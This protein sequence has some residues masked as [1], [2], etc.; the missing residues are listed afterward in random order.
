MPSTIEL[1]ILAQE[2]RLTQA[3]RTLDVE[4]LDRLYA[5][6]ILM[7]SVLGESCDKTFL[8]D[9]AK[10]GVA[11]RAAAGSAGKDFV[12][13]YDKEELKM[14]VYG[15]AAVTTYRFIVTFKGDGIDVRRKYRTTNV[16]VKRAERWQVVAAHTAFVLDPKQIAALA[17]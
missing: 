2:D 13:S 6:D 5:D 15:D 1:E 10:R 17:G 12:S 16:W 14:A 7:T 8:M 9:E 11:Q 4:A 3:S